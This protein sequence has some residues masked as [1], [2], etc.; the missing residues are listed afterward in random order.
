MI[1]LSI[2]SDDFGLS[3]EI[4]KG[5]L[6]AFKNNVLTDA[7]LM[8]NGPNYK[9]AV[10]LAK[11]YKIPIAAH[12]N[13]IRGKMLTD[14]E[15]PSSIINFWSR[16]FN[17]K[18]LF[19]IEKEAR[20]QIEKILKDN[21]SIYQINS[22]KHSHFFPK[23]FKLWIN[24]AVEYKIPYIRFI[25]EFN[26]TFSLQ[27]GKAN[28]L[29]TFSLLNEKFLR[30]SP[31]KKTDYFKGI[32]ATGKLNFLRLKKEMKKLKEGWTEFMV[33]I[34]YH[35]EIDQTMG[36]YFLSNTR[37]EELKSLFNPSFKDIISSLKIKLRSFG[38]KDEQ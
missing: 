10:E 15:K 14:F 9:E 2:N 21:I 8:P 13:L 38:G 26:L 32:L 12:I 4:D 33:H 24:L 1:Y 30:D 29:S 19:K 37:E 11:E 23:I 3:K 22:E 31:V 6:E 25:R 7:S 35:G 17:K 27:G 34:G 36:S 28:L 18:Y 16:S 5:I 20:A